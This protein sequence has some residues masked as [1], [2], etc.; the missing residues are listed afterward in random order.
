M[1]RALAR[2]LLPQ[3][4]SWQ[5][6]RLISTSSTDLNQK[7]QRLVRVC[8]QVDTQSK[9]EHWGSLEARHNSRGVQAAMGEGAVDTPTGL[10]CTI[11]KQGEWLLVSACSHTIK[12]ELQ[13]VFRNT[14]STPWVFPSTVIL[15]CIIINWECKT[16]SHIWLSKTKKIFLLKSKKKMYN[17]GEVQGKLK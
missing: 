14:K 1:P 8:Y 7:I 12:K 13:A 4:Q 16:I 3:R 9:K 11:L 15:H 2:G 17:P 5:L 10:Q 6:G